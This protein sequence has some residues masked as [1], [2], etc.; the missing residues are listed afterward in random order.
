MRLRTDLLPLLLLSALVG[1]GAKGGTGDGSSSATS[2]AKDGKSPAVE[3][4]AARAAACAPIDLGK[5]Q[6]VGT[7][8]VDGGALDLVREAGE[9]NA[10]W[11]A[12]PVDVTDLQLI[13]V[14]KQGPRLKE[15]ADGVAIAFVD[16]DVPKEPGAGGPSL[17]VPTKPIAAAGIHYLQDDKDFALELWKGNE[18]VPYL[19]TPAAIEKLPRAAGDRLVELAVKG[20]E[21]TFALHTTAEQ[22]SPATVAKAKLG[23]SGKRA[24]GLTGSTGVYLAQLGWKDVR[25][26]VGK[27]CLK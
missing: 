27:E 19:D 8:K 21:V 2:G 23:L 11:F 17:G 24:L 4:I 15:F 16:G 5:L 25:V 6:L 14:L 10:A 9:S 26:A 22:T 13:A 3:P 18:G 20:G 12:E 1:C 7:A